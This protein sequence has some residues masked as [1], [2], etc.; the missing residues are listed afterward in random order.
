M[1]QRGECSNMNISCRSLRIKIV[2]VFCGFSI[3]LGVSLVAGILI[4]TKYAEKYALKKRLELEISRYLESVVNPP[5]APVVFRTEVTLP[6]SPYMSSYL[7]EDLLPEWAAKTLPSLPDGDYERKNDKQ[8]YYVVIRDLRNDE[9]FYLL[10]NTTTL[11]SDHATMNI[12]RG[13]LMAALL[14]T[15]IVGLL[16]GTITAYKVVSPV[17]H[18]TDIVKK[19][20]KTGT[21]P[22]NL[23]EGFDNNEVGI[24][25]EAL[26]Y[27]M[28]EMQMAM[29][30]EKAF[31]RDASH[32]LRTPVTIISG[33]VKILYEE[34][35]MDNAN[36]R[37]F[38]SK[39]TRANAK[40]E[41]MINSFLWLSKQERNDTE[42]ICTPADVI[43]EA[44]ENSRYLIMDKPLVIEVNEFSEGCLSVAPEIFSIIISNIIRNAI[45]YTH[46]G[47]VIVSV[48]ETCISVRDTGPGIPSQVI[49]NIN[50]EKGVRM[51]EGF[52]F[53]LSIAHRMCVQLGWEFHIARGPRGKGTEVTICW[54]ENALAPEKLEESE[55]T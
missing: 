3:L 33:A 6:R 38:M 39:I 1:K 12:S 18:L 52:G 8:S 47:K 53:G 50:G 22:E 27:S 29:N 49:E 11:L 4:S 45:T 55:E 2:I 5:L 24:L 9:R 17:V 23:S 46:E 36:I 31:A 21:L 15:L 13:Y 26:E 42:S 10:Y 40:M 54:G 32:E 14:P 37:R 7:S 19:T 25:A 51:A 35:D 43:K 16:L 41:H 34:V 48:H 28:Q 44:I 20:G 30:R